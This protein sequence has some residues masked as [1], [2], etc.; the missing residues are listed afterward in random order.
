MA[1]D[2]ILLSFQTIM[3][4]GCKAWR[5]RAAVC[6]DCGAAPQPWEVQIDVARRARI[7]DEC[8]QSERTQ[9]LAA[10]NWQESLAEVPKILRR[11]NRSLQRAATFKSGSEQ[12]LFAFAELDSQINSWRIR[13]PR[14][15][16]NQGRVFHRSLVSLRDGYEIF[17]RAVAAPEPSEA[18]RLERAGQALLDQA[19]TIVG[20]L[21][22]LDEAQSNLDLPINEYYAHIARETRI[23]DGLDAE[24]TDLDSLINSSDPEAADITSYAIRQMLITVLD[25]EQ[26][27]SVAHLT[28]S[29]LSNEA[30]LYV[31]EPWLREHSRTTSLLAASAYA[32]AGMD[33]DATEFETARLLL[34]LVK[35]SREAVIRHALATLLAAD[36]NEYMKLLRSSTGSVIKKASAVHP[37]LRLNENL[38]P[39]L[40]HAVAH[41]D[42]DWED[43]HLIT[44]PNG[45]EVR[46]E[47]STFI[48]GCLAYLES[49][50]SLLLGIHH[51]AQSIGQ[52]INA[53]S[54]LSNRDRESALT[55]ALSYLGFDDVQVT[56]GRDTT[57]VLATGDPSRFVMIA[58]CVA[59]LSP[60]SHATLKLQIVD[61]AGTVH[62]CTTDLRV[63]RRFRPTT[64]VEDQELVSR[65]AELMSVSLV[66]GISPWSESEWLN[67]AF[68][69]STRNESESPLQPI[70]R[71]LRLKALAELA[72]ISTKD[73]ESWNMLLAHLRTPAPNSPMSIPAAYRRG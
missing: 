27:L 5:S 9:A 10:T 2:A 41:S 23:A 56:F 7:V 24:V 53:D 14:P 71:V 60:D 26:G 61:Q 30:G 25:L 35:D 34:E 3:C 63:V 49:A 47:E 43:G 22:V 59:T 58:G 18:Q 65:A 62:P 38:D 70:R 45:V 17:L 54:H 1:K 6:P 37:E 51:H 40:R 48:D 20:E 29:L 72:G 28:T 11:I 52:P 8:L 21:E 12:V 55:M 15:H 50:S 32:L 46:I 44:H 31:N 13:R 68:A 4:D 67:A 57:T 64:T 36:P 69:V 73:D 66:D 16:T 39:I 42:F 33:D 19:A